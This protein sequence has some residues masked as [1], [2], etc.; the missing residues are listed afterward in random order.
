MLLIA[1]II[2]GILAAIGVIAFVTFCAVVYYFKRT[3]KDCM[4]QDSEVPLKIHLHED[5]VAEWLD[6]NEAQKL[7]AEFENLGFSKGPAYLVEEMEE[8]SCL[9]LFHEKY[10]AVL[11]CVDSMGHFYDIL[12]MESKDQA[13]T[14]TTMPFAGDFESP[15]GKEKC[16]LEGASVVELYDAVVKKTEGLETYTI[17][18]EEFRECVETY[19]K[20]EQAYRIRHGGV[21]YDEFLSVANKNKRSI[22]D[23]KIRTAFVSFKKNELETWSDAAVEEYLKNH[24]M[25]VQERESYGAYFIVP[26]KTDAEAFVHYLNDFDLVLDEHVDKI[27]ENV[28]SEQDIRVLF[29]RINN[30]RSPDLRAVKRMEIDFPIAGDLYQA[31]A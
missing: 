14:V 12:H 28:R 23:K 27:G 17:S 1:K 13:L 18:P 2:L 26:S 19:Y 11:Y 21:S 9:S 7:V 31:A 10:T 4:N 5:L 29:E 22:S 3:F 15:P 16:Y 6:T 24:E 25:S 30:S 8:L 20:E